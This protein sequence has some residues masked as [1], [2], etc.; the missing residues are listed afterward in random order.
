MIAI[1]GISYNYHDSAAA[2]IVDGKIIAAA[3]E[4]R[5]TRIKHD[6]SF[7]KQAIAYCLRE[8]SLNGAD[9]SH[10][11]FYEKPF[12]KFSRL[13]ETYHNFAP[14]GLRSFLKAMPVWLKDKLYTRRRI[15]EALRD[16][17]IVAPILFTDHH[18]S[19]AA[20]AFYP[21]PYADA[22]ILTIDGVGEWD[23]TTICYGE[24][25]KITRLRSIEFPHSLGLFYSAVTYYCGFRVNSGE[26]KLMGLAPY[27]IDDDD[28]K[29]MRE[30][31]L[32]E[33]ISLKDDGSFKLNM[34]YFDYA[35]GLRMTRDDAWQRLL[36]VARRQ[37]DEELQPCHL[38]LARACQM[39]T[40]EIVVR[41]AR[42]A[43]RLTGCPRLVMAGGVALNCVA[44]GRL[45][46]EQIFDS[47]WVQPASG[48]AGGALG[49]ALGAWHI[50]LSKARTPILPDA[51]QGAYLGSEPN[52]TEIER[53]IERN[54][55]VAHRLSPENLY[56]QTA[57]YIADGKIVGW[58]QGRMEFGPR[59]LGNRS[60]L[61]DARNPEMQRRLNLAVKRRESFRPFAPA[62]LAEDAHRY[63]A[64]DGESPYMLFTAE[65][66]DSIRRQ[67]PDDYHNRPY[68]ERLYVERSELQ[69]VTHVDF[70]ARVQT[71]S[72]QA[73]APFYDL[74]SA[75]RQ[76]S[77]CG[78][79]VNTSFNVRGE[80]IVCSPD[81]AYRCFIHTDIDILVI[82]NYL[83]LKEEQP[84]SSTPAPTFMP[85]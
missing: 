66:A 75:F 82:G 74:I 11:V 14:R 32:S 16:Y 6:A 46:R 7:P 40:E 38:R 62:V 2:I 54:D 36:G 63:F 27:G 70:S 61:A 44:N 55:A 85:D 10:V 78:V 12:I 58:M 68:M 30:L 43:R 52:N 48:D 84:T 73:N 80:P 25:N 24:E 83:F 5:F 56:Q 28:T 37:A 51:M 50:H 1:L 33:I 42:T 65:V 47:I 31:I 72:R 41:L 21:S 29:K 57:Q 22:A 23:T 60:I 81:D 45:R 79:V 26:Y 59:A 71:V 77:G 8:A 69:A 17:D 19:H 64:L 53:M 15:A 18:L 76:L 67:L 49:A 3:Q 39:I 35:T 13:L 4:E 20:S 34:R 9:I